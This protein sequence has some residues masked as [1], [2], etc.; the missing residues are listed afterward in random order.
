LVEPRH[1]RRVE[2]M[3]LHLRIV[4]ATILVLLGVDGAAVG[5]IRTVLPLHV[6]MGE[7]FP[8]QLDAL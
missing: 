4:W 8:Q 1:P 7:G 3:G 6:F 5:D 2:E